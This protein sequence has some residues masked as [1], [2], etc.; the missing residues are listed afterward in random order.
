MSGEADAALLLPGLE[1]NAVVAASAGTGKTQLITS[2]YL[3]HVLGLR[4]D[5]RRI[6]AERIVATT[7]SRAAAREIRERL[8]QRL[9][10]IAGEVHPSTAVGVDAALERLVDQH[11]LDARELR[12]R[13][14][15]ALA[16]LPR[17]LIDTLHGLAAR[18]LRTHG[19]ELGV[20]PGFS[21][22]DEQQA[23]EEADAVIEEV[24]S[25]AL[26]Q[27][28]ARE[29]AVVALIDAASGLEP[30]RN[31]LHGFVSL[32]D[33]E[34]LDA[35][36]LAI[37]D[38]GR[39]AA[40]L[41][42]TLRQGAR[43][44]ASS[45]LG[46]TEQRSAERT[47]R[48]LGVSPLDVP[49]LAA[50]VPDWLLAKKG[51]SKSRLPPAIDAAFDALLK[52][53][54]SC[55]KLERVRASL[56]FL[57]HAPRLSS[58]AWHIAEVVAAIQRRLRERHRLRGVL[59]FGDLLRLARDGLRD[60][61]VLAARAAEELDL[62]LVDEFQ[63]TSRVQR[64][65]L[66]L[67]RERPE[68]ARARRPGALP[69]VE[70]LS[71]GGLVIV[72][73]RKQSIYAFRGA[74]VS[75]Y[76][77]LAAELAG[78]EAAHALDLQG[79]PINATPVAD[80]HPL[81]N[82]YRSEGAILHFVNAVSE[83]D[84]SAAP[85]RSFEIR[86]MPAESLVPPPGKPLEGGRITVLRDDG[87]IPADADA[88]VSSARG[89]L[90]TALL[91]A[92]YCA[93]AHAEG[94][95]LSDIAILAR[96]RSTLPLVEL[97][98]DRLAIP[99]VVAGRALY[100]T[101]EVRDLAALLRVALDVHDR[102]AL[103]VV[104]RS[105][106]GGLADTTLVELSLPGRGLLPPR[107]WQQQ[108]VT[109][110][111]ERTKVLELSERLLEFSAV[112]PRLSPRDALA[113]ATERFELERVLAALPRGAVR[114][115]N[116]GRLLEIAARHGGSLPVFVRWL[117][118]QIALEVDESEA[119]VFSDDDDAVRLLTIHASKGLAF[120]V[121]V[122]LDLGAVEQPRYPALALLRRDDG[123]AELVV[124]HR[125]EEG[126]IATPA[127]GEWS[128]EARLRATAERQRLSYVAMTRARR[129]LVLALPAE[130]ARAGSL[131]ESVARVLGC[132]E[133]TPSP[134]L[135]SLE[136]DVL[137]GA[138]P[139]ATA[140]ADGTVLVPTRPEQPPWN[141]SAIGV[142]ALADYAICA[143]RFAL[144]HTVG[145]AE[146]EPP[147]P[148]AVRGDR[149]GNED[150]RALGSAAHQALELFP[151]EAWGET[152]ALDSVLE[153]LA[154]QGLDVDAPEAQRT[155]LGIQRFLQSPFARSTREPGTRVHREIELPL[156]L[157][158]SDT[159]GARQLTLFAPAPMERRVLLKA[160][161][162]LVV[163]HADGSVDVIDYKR[164]RASEPSR[165]FLQ[166]HAYR[167]AVQ[168]NF[169]AR[170]VR[171]GLVHL[172]GEA[173][174][175][176]WIDPPPVQLAELAVRLAASRYNADLPLIPVHRCRQARCGFVRACHPQ[177][178]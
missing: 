173:S 115:G 31:L 149:R 152:L 132:A 74:D 134:A 175:P 174:E 8:E 150:V 104:A 49:E 153:A 70:A 141:A 54:K 176:D 128:E 33:E 162:D 82:N 127:L 157:D 106:L 168:Q 58:E 48:A 164:A 133:L 114:F 39:H 76:T 42:E 65:L 93:L 28:D 169:A 92:G 3:A 5:G 135:R 105:P 108:N 87:S 126:P 22:L 41:I 98:L 71:A 75:V 144:L 154:R 11:H 29:N 35:D 2:I 69:P 155:A 78:Q 80:F 14:L 103:A 95:P 23:F 57:K 67:L 94:T 88:L 119:A 15:S 142:T 118:R 139:A 18:V 125:S 120:P 172:L 47:L 17:T 117:D 55:S 16:E 161:L 151:L 97:A 165:Y 26:S 45:E 13:A 129:E 6:A 21:I 86:Y 90:R 72:G 40:Q 143:R 124:R 91:A 79:V 171:T 109:L 147:Q 73:D 12:V 131:A 83:V 136:P 34:G 167:L 30:A 81:R 59:S 85:R 32:L 20:L 43:S 53:N 111:S 130:S 7:F 62:L 61:P 158:A 163:V 99:F 123:T 102:H 46:E 146:P 50:C 25:Q 159:G 140:H 101:S 113:F 122:L 112:A 77:R 96:R 66:L 100:A 166:L 89:N 110:L 51:R 1:R 156:L 145:L 177:T 10:V 19:V 44:V 56:Q 68:L 60:A 63:D 121:T 116:V 148:A 36:A 4:R 170:S 24:L 84:F 52:P 160:T 37:S 38:H 138:R 107:L 64:D 178:S 9:A 27:G 137:L